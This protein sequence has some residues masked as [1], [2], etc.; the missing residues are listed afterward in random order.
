MSLYLSSHVPAQSQG[1]ILMGGGENRPW[2]KLAVSLVETHGRDP[3][4]MDSFHSFN[5][6]LLTVSC[7]LRHSES[8]VKTDSVPVLKA[9]TVYTGRQTLIKHKHNCVNCGKC[10]EKG[11]VCCERGK[12]E[13]AQAWGLET[14]K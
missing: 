7:V 5:K 3:D 11:T 9:F 1:L 13:F 12:Q 4:Y 8:G 14:E 2:E 10:C 6:Y